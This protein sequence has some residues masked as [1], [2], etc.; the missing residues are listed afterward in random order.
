MAT[1][2]IRPMVI[3]QGNSGLGVYKQPG[4]AI[5]EGQVLTPTAT[6]YTQAAALAVGNDLVLSLQNSSANAFETRMVAVQG[7][8]YD[9]EL[10][11]TLGN[12]VS[13]TTN[14]APGKKYALGYD[15]ATGNF[16]LNGSVTS[17][18]FGEI[19]AFI[20]NDIN[21]KIGDTNVRVKFRVTP[22]L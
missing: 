1:L 14:T 10:T 22:V 5:Q 11:A 18:P 2:P 12:V 20:P 15:S 21:G 19:V 16:F 3:H 7:L 9:I 4:V 17:T 8:G 6:G 13:D